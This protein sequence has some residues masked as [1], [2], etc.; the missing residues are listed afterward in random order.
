MKLFKIFNF[1]TAVLL[2][3][4]TSC[5]KNLDLTPS[6][7]IDASK[8]YR[9]IPDINLGLIGAYAV[10]GTS[11]ITNTSLISDEAML[12][13]ENTTGRNVATYRWQFDGSNETITAG[14]DNNYIA[15]DR[16]NRVLGSIDIVPV[17]PQ[18]RQLKKGTE[19]NCWPCGLTAILNCCA[20]LHLRTK[21]TEWELRIWKNLKTQSP[22]GFQ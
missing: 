15:I 17:D 1:F 13:T 3:A 11:S 19:E 7:F 9:N 18:K 20:N 5:N 10:L 21:Q 14:F 6:D 22:Q 12:P 16:I 8:A 4:A 2:L